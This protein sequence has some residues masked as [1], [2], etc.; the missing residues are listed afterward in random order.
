MSMTGNFV[1]I[2]PTQLDSLKLQ[3]DSVEDLLDADEHGFANSCDVDKSWHGIHF[4]L[5]GKPWGGTGPEAKAV[6]GG[7]EIGPDLGYGPARYLSADEVREVAQVLDQISITE[8]QARFDAD[9]MTAA[10]LYSFD[11]E[12][13]D[14]ELEYITTYY[15]QLQQFY[16][17][18]ADGGNAMLL[19]LL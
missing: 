11:A 19:F 5:T 3:P 15:E 17:T 2:S 1:Q 18:T 4:L 12:Y 7:T 16:R 13:P 14:D 8:I 10:D 6:L 9:A